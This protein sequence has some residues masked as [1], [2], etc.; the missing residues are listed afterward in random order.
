MVFI[1]L[2]LPL[3]IVAA[4]IV[5]LAS[6]NGFEGLMSVLKVFA[7]SFLIGAISS[8]ASMAFS[9]AKFKKTEN[10]DT[11]NAS[12]RKGSGLALLIPLIVGVLILPFLP[13]LLG[14][15]GLGILYTL[16][17]SIILY[18]SGMITGWTVATR[19]YKKQ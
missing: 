14:L 2:L 9:L 6:G 3:G 16:G 19:R 18:I 12:S 10:V 17:V 15:G 4:L 5:P 7:V 1:K 8:Y 11:L 13:F